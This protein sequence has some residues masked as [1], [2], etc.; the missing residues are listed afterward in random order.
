[1]QQIILIFGIVMKKENTALNKAFSSLFNVLRGV[2]SNNNS[3]INDSTTDLNE[4]YFFM[5]RVYNDWIGVDEGLK[6][7]T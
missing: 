2:E 1:M 5:D 7:Y 6:V 3:L 4:Y